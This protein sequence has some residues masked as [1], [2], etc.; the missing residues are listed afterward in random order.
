MGT[1]IIQAA[2]EVTERYDMLDDMLELVA[3]LEHFGTGR[4]VQK[5]L[6]ELLPVDD[7]DGF[8]Q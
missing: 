3:H 6:F 1:G 7:A 4:R 2:L 8:G 5:F